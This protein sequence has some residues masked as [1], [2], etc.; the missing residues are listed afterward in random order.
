ME[1]AT[2]FSNGRAYF[3][4]FNKDNDASQKTKLSGV[5]YFRLN[6]IGYI[7]HKLGFASKVHY[8]NADKHGVVYLSSKNFNAWKERHKNDVGVNCQSL[9]QAF[10]QKKFEETIAIICDAFAKANPKVVNET[11]PQQVLTHEQLIAQAEVS[12]NKNLLMIQKPI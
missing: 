4:T 7:L 10:S 11:K 9:D 8:V 1:I 2:E 12:I 3:G 6:I 5:S